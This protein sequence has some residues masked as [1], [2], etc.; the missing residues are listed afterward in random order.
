MDSLEKKNKQK[1][2]YDLGSKLIVVANG[3]YKEYNLMNALNT[4]F[5]WLEVLYRKW[6]LH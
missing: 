4:I 3:H 5:P 2:P 1:K 6:L